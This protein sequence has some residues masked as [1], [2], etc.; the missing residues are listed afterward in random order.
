[1]AVPINQSDNLNLVNTTQLKNLSKFAFLA[2]SALA[3]AASANAAYV[4]GDLIAGFTGGS[5]DVIFDLGQASA[6]FPGETWTISLTSQTDFGI[7]GAQTA[8]KHIFATAFDQTENG[9]VQDGQYQ[10]ARGNILSL[11]GG[12]LVAGT[13]ATPLATDSTSWTFQTAQPAGTPG[14]TFQNNYFNPNVPLAATAYLFDNVSGT[15][16]PVGGF[17]YDAGRSTLTVQPA[18]EPG[19]YALLG[20][21]GVLAL[22]FRRKSVKA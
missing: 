2:V 13:S 22:A 5:T 14:N 1:M 11:A 15:T 16:T 8:G 10:T 4:N 18:P 6:L 21:G 19:T 12:G 20:L 7:I 3:L 17:Q 9:W